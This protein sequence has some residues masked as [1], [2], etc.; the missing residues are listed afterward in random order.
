MHDV[1]RTCDHETAGLLDDVPQD[2]PDGLHLTDQACGLAHEDAGVIRIARP[3]GGP[4]TLVLDLV[5]RR[6]GQSG[7]PSA[8]S[9]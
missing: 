1:L 2:A 7:L 5:R 9:G 6:V 3:E 4:V 8:L